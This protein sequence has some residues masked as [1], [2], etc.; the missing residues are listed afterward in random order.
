MSKY[1]TPINLH[2][3]TIT[4]PGITQEQV[5]KGLLTMME[6]LKDEQNLYYENPT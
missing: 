3:Y 2:S 5:N 1:Y 6:W 4:T